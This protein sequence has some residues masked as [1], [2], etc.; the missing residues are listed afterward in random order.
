MRDVFTYFLVIALAFMWTHPKP[1]MKAYTITVNAL[2]ADY[3]HDA[4]CGEL[5]Y[6]ALP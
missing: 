4:V 6:I 1:A 2:C 3:P 5:K